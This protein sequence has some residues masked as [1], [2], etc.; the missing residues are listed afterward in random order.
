MAMLLFVL[1]L[2]LLFLRLGFWQL[3]RK[4]ERLEENAVLTRRLSEDPLPVTSA[5]AAAGPD[6][7][8]LDNR[9]GSA[10]GSFR[11]DLEILVRNRTN[12]LG[13]AGFH[14]LTPLE[15]EDGTLV[16][17][18]RGWIP[19]DL[20][21]VP[22]QELPP[23]SGKVEVNGLIRMS[24]SRPPVGSIDPPGSLTVVNRIDLERIGMLFQA[25][26]EK[27]WLQLLDSGPSGLPD[28][29]AP[30]DTVGEGPHLSYAIQWFSF[31]ATALIGFGFVLRRAATPGRRHLPPLEHTREH[32]Q[33]GRPV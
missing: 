28:A 16:V 18:N 2:S 21:R 17:V 10:V 20:D 5:V 8:S 25:P 9:P 4:A 22:V 29:L 32:P 3:D 30:P 26:V 19:L 11:P 33:V 13:T 24:E 1:A 15:L 31:A 7:E 23:P 27:V 12:T 14:L 6:L